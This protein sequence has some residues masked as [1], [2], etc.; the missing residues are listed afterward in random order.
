MLAGDLEG[1]SHSVWARLDAE[2]SGAE[3]AIISC[4]ALLRVDFTAAGT[5]L[6]WVTERDARGERVE[7]VDA[8]RL[9][10]AFF[11]VIGIADHAIVAVR[12]D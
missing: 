12:A 8:H 3:A 2:M 5:L 7:F 10:A 4:T 9:V 1:E 6:N 11:N